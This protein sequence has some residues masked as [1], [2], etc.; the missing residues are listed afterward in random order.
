MRILFGG[1]Q[2]TRE[3]TWTPSSSSF[4][5]DL[6]ILVPSS[7]PNT[8]NTQNDVQQETFEENGMEEPMANVRRKR[9]CPSKSK[10]DVR[11]GKFDEN[12]ERL[13][14]VLEQESKHDCTCVLNQ[15]RDGAQVINNI[16][17]FGHA[18]YQGKRTK[19]ERPPELT[20]DPTGLPRLNNRVQEE[21]M[22][23]Q[24]VAALQTNLTMSESLQTT[25]SSENAPSVHLPTAKWWVAFDLYQWE[26]FWYTLPRL[27][28]TIAM[29]NHFKSLDD[30][31]ILA[32]SIKT[33]TALIKALVPSIMANRILTN[34]Q[35]PLLTN[36]P[37]VLMPSLEFKISR[38]NPTPNL[39]EMLSSRLFRTHVP[40]RELPESIKNSKCR[41]VYQSRSLKDTFVSMRPF[42]ITLISDEEGPFPIEEACENFFD[43]V[44]AFG[45]FFDHALEYWKVSLEKPNKILFLTYEEMKHD[46]KRQ[47]KRLAEFLGR[48]FEREE[49]RGRV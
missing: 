40:Y 43:G 21:R 19:I 32:S 49:E 28:A 3:E 27:Q 17:V 14:N 34:E 7:P 4:P 1:T 23:F 29:Q 9:P 12:L 30:D 39:S 44:S 22:H 2:A 48:P 16:L 35:D 41:I 18:P 33:G 13:V 38:E 31:V 24:E 26:R 37:N 5:E 25:S 8:G 15:D 20:M 45:P 46:P 36:H 11:N 10:R 47:V 6:N 42:L